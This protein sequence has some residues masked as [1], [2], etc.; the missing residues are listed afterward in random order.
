MPLEAFQSLTIIT[1]TP[2]AE[3]GDKTSLVIDAVTRSG[4]GLKRP[5]GSLAVASRLVFRPFSRRRL[6]ES[7]AS[8]GETFRRSL[9]IGQSVFSTRPNL[10]P[11]TTTARQSTFS[12][13]P[14]TA[15]PK[16]IRFD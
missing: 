5:T 16:K 10:N 7:A 15:R 2:N 4:L 12:T 9:L 14:I 13:V 3:Y 1:G 11:C 8:V 6:S